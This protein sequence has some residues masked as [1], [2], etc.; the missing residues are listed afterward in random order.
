M[1]MGMWIDFENPMDMGMS[2][3][4]TFENGYECRYNY[5][6]PTPIPNSIRLGRIEKIVWIIGNQIK[7]EKRDCRNEL[8]VVAPSPG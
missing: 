8:Y 6:R 7:K 3:G 5:T 2:M 4:M 1:G